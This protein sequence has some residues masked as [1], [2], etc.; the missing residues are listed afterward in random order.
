TLIEMAVVLVLV[1]IVIS[2]MAT[3]LPTLIQSAKIR[4]G[5]AVIEKIDYS[6]EGYIASS[7]RCP[8]PDTDADGLENRNDGGSPGDPVDDTCTAY[9]GGLPYLTLGLSTGDD[10]W[11]NPVRYGVYEDFIKTTTS[12]LCTSLDSF[13]ASPNPAFLRTTSAQAYVIASGGPQDLDGANGFFDGLNGSS[14]DVQFEIPDKVMDATYDDLV[15]SVSFVYLKGKIC[16]GGT[17][18]GPG[19]DC[20]NV[21]SIYCGNCDDG[22]NNDSDTEGPDCLDPDCATHPNCANPTCDI[23]TASPLAPGTLNSDY[24]VTFTASAGCIG[25]LEW[26]LS[27][28]GGFTD[29]Y[30]HTYSGHLSGTL[31]QCPGSYTINVG[32]VDSDGDNDPDPTN[33]FTIDITADLAVACQSGCGQG[34]CSAG[35]DICWDSST[36]QVQFAVNGGHK[37]AIDWG[38][39]S[40]GATGFVVVSTGDDTGVIKKDSA[41]T[42]GTYTFT[43]TAT[44]PDCPG[45]SADLILSVEVT[46]DG[47]GAPY[48]EGMEAEWRFDECTAWDGASFD[49]VDANGDSNHFGK[50]EGGMAAISSGKNCRAAAF[51]GVDDKIVSKVL[52]GGDIMAFNDQVTLAC[53]FKSPG[54]GGTYPRLIEFSDAAGSSS[55]STALAYDPDGSLRAWV[56]EQGTGTRG[57]SIDYSAELYNDNQ[58]HHAAYTYDSVNGGKLYVDGVLKQTSTS[59]L[60]AD[61]QDAETFVIGGYYPSS[62]HEFRGLIDEVMVFHSELTAAEVVELYSLSRSACTGSCYTAPVAEYQMDGYGWNGTADEVLDSGTG[63]SHGTALAMGTGAL[64]VQTSPSGGKVCRAGEFTRV[65]GNNGGY[66]DLGDPGD[67]DLDPGTAPWTISAWIKWDGSSGENIIYNKEGLY[68]ARVSG[69]Y[70]QYAWQPHWAWDGGAAFPVTAGEWTYVTTLY[71]GASQVLFKNGVQVFSRD[72]AGAMG[73]NSN[74]LRIGARGTTTP[75][76]FFGGM[77]DEVKVHNRALAENEIKAN[78]AATRSCAADSVT[79]TTATLSDGVMGSPYSDVVAATRG[80]AP[81]GWQITASAVPGL[82]I[83]PNTGQL[84]GIIDVCAGDHNI[85][86]KVTDAGGS[87]DEKTFTLAVANGTLTMVP[88]SP[89]TFNC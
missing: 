10:N 24:A 71:D 86:V 38:L 13:I 79:I 77:I 63:A 45:N 42:A 66:L 40:G 49:V 30:L 17:P 19:G 2:I 54:G 76:N 57:A 72:Q 37:G 80:T 51:D 12:G 26:D 47:T 69:G 62:G 55:R 83:V 29:F 22:L 70:F 81:Y 11:H 50:A 85:T 65:D 16:S 34:S 53:W 87:M 43:L 48:T 78:M 20:S 35:T 36:K 18:P 3:V 21:E 82:T 6:L 5:R 33:P 64:P 59:S 41:T 84:T 1:G 68:E 56:T 28:D 4:K 74:S 44:D 52:T 15:R 32:V 8:C 89:K 75:R 27:G 88:S 23:V 25:S 58:W 61:I 9:T 39:N 14:P 31:S 7:G 60:T 73:Q 46:A 67:G